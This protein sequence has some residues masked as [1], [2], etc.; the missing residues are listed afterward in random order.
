L[1]RSRAPLSVAILGTGAMGRYWAYRLRAVHPWVIGTVPPPYEIFDGHTKVVLVPRYYPWHESPP[2]AP[3]VVLLAVKWRQLQTAADWIRRHA[4]DSILVSLMNGMG[5]EEALRPLDHAILLCGAT[6]AAATRDDR[7]AHTIRVQSHGL[8]F[9]PA[10]P[11]HE[12]VQALATLSQAHHWAWAWVSTA[13]IL[14]RRWVKLLQNSV[15]NPLTALADCPNGEVIRH[16]IWRLATPLLTEGMQVAA[17]QHVPLPDD[18]FSSIVTLA[19]NTAANL[20]S[21]LQD[22]RAG[23]IT[24]IEAINGYLVRTADAA[25]IPVPTHRAI[26]HLIH[27]LEP[28]VTS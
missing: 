14:Q 5:Q 3:D 1:E 8:T 12:G 24:E 20:S 22:V 21:M 18:L 16:P 27:G 19:E 17:R 28:Q 10:I 9:V 7:E 2:A 6:T 15:I 11:E 13:D 25:Q 26:V 23:E 4:A